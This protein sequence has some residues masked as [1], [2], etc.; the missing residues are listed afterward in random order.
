MKCLHRL[1]CSNI[2]SP[3]DST[4]WEVCGTPLKHMEEPAV[5]HMELAL[6]V[7][8]TSGSA[9]SFLLIVWELSV[10]SFPHHDGFCLLVCLPACLSACLSLGAG[11]LLLLQGRM[12]SEP[13]GWEAHEST[14]GLTC[15]NACRPVGWRCAGMQ[16]NPRGSE[17]PP[18]QERWGRT[19]NK[20]A[21]GF[22]S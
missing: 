22:S 3:G 2:W 21:S 1:T 11:L 17:T 9:L 18:A 16:G 5:N 10:M 6:R 12:S 13:E 7:T 14:G 19:P 15:G 20:A 8:P 4:L